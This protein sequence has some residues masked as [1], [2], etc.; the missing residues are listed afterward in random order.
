MKLLFRYIGIT[1]LGFIIWGAAI[2]QAETLQEAVQHMLQT[3]PEI[4]SLAYNRLA[5]DQEITQA[6][7][8]YLPIIDISYGAGYEDQD[9]PFD[10]TTH[11]QSTILSLRQNVFRGFADQYEIKRQEARVNSAAYLLQGTSENIGL[12]TSRAYLNVLRQL[13]IQDLSKENLINHQR[14]YD[15]IKLRSESGIDRKADLDQV[16]A[17]L[18]LAESDVVVSAAN[19]DDAQTDYQFVVGHKPE[20]LVKP[21]RVDSLMPASLEEAQQLAL[22]NYP[23]LK[24][25]QADLQAREAQHIVAK[26]NYYPELDIAVDQKW[27]DEVDY[28]GYQEELSAI[29]LVRFNIFN[30]FSDKARIAET[31][32]LISEA[33]EIQNNTHRQIIESIRLSWVAYTSSRN[34]ITYLE[35]YVKSTGL[36]AEAFSKQWNIGRR[37]MFDVL[38]IE[39]ELINSKIDL[40]NAQYDKTYAQFRLLSGI[41]QLVHTLG[42]EWPEESMVEEDEQ[43]KEEAQQENKSAAT[44]DKKS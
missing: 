24:S 10:D 17:R 26:S 18:A 11:P 19:V 20:N 43:Q 5:R 38:D 7:A 22:D 14:I 4:R 31:S 33:R 16:M 40:V 34:R 1:S 15:Q 41:G 25:A 2:S 32:H 30:G 28:S 3:N 27:E 36:T 23:I 13:E 9:H 29:A 12:V 6:R 44:G 8:G 42:L 37:T 35:N 39:A 21:P